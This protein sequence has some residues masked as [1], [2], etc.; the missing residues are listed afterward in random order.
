MYKKFLIA[1]V[2]L[3][4]LAM[5]ALGY[6]L[7][8]GEMVDASQ[9]ELDCRQTDNQLT[10]NIFT[11]SSGIA[12]RGLRLRQHGTTLDIT[13]R[14]VPVTAL[15]ASGQVQKTLELTGIQEVRFAGHVIWSRAK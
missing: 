4:F 10:L 1:M 12:L 6:F 11:T 2:V 3:F 14:K 8:I 13:L 15:N 7:C 5:A 9:V